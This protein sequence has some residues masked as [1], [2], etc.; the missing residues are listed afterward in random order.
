MAAALLGA[1]PSIGS[2]QTS[3]MSGITSFIQKGFSV[4][5][6]GLFILAGGVP[7]P[8]LSYLGFGGLNLWAV[9]SMTYFAMKAGLQ[10]MCVLANTYVTAYYPNLWWVGYLMVLNPWYVFDLVQ[11]FSPAFAAEGFKVPLLHTPIGH[12]GTGT[13]TA[14]LL[15]AAIALLC[16]GAYSLISLLPSE[17]QVTYKPI[18]NSVFLA[19][20]GITALGGGSIGSM[21]VIP[22]IMSAIKGNI[23]DAGAAVAAL[24]PPSGPQAGGGGIPSLGDV[25]NN[26]IN[27]AEQSGGGGDGPDIGANIFLGTLVVAALGGI[28][29]ALIRTKAVSTG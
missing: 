13:V 22:K 21:L 29:L 19:I 27:G 2:V 6:F 12:G 14:A 23:S 9:G 28:S 10:A 16:S 26:I 11:M 1:T 15:A 25:A 5:W 7:F 24:P 8:P 4:G 17:L 3:G 18:M 20:G